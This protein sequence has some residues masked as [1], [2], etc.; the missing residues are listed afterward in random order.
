[1]YKEIKPDVKLVLKY[2]H[3]AIKASMD[4]VK[5]MLIFSVILC[6]CPCW[7]VN[8]VHIS[9]TCTSTDSTLDLNVKANLNFDLNSILNIVT[10][11]YIPSLSVL[12]LYKSHSI[13][14]SQFVFIFR[15]HVP[16]SLFL[17]HDMN[18]LSRQGLA[19]SRLGLFSCHIYLVFMRYIYFCLL[20]LKL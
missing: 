7:V 8:R 16:P 9:P 19:Y 1:M 12:K 13:T 4:L 5:Q 17:K 3:L 18:G 11:N 14:D 15:T 6:A 10:Q 20:L 2:S